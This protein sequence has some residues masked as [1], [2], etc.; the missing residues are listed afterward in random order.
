MISDNVV[1][2][3]SP[4]EVQFQEN[5]P[6][7]TEGIELF[8]KAG[9]FYSRRVGNTPGGYNAVRNMVN[10]N[11]NLSIISNPGITQLY[12]ASKFSGRN[13]KKLGIGVFNALAAPMHAVV[14]DKTTGAQHA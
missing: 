14:E 8:N 10:N 2:N 11:P 12:N 4:F 3:L 5:R 7:F 1:L 13:K 6:F 9:L